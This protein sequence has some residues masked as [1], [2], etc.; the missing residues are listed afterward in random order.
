MDPSQWYSSISVA[1]AT[2][3]VAITAY[4]WRR[5]PNRRAADTFVTA[6]TFFLLAAAFAYLLRTSAYDPAGTNDTPLLFARMFYFFHML[7]VGF[8]AAFIGSYF[9]GFQIMRRRV[10]GLGLQISL[11]VVAIL[12]A[13]QV[14]DLESEVQDGVT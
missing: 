3:A 12:V 14:T 9:Y 8:T 4:V 1:S 11:F 13:V 6:M 7:A 5:S 10:V 2:I